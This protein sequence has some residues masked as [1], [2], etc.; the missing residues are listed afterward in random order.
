MT[1]SEFAWE[2]RRH[3]FK[4]SYPRALAPWP[5]ALPAD[6]PAAERERLQARVAELERGAQYGWGQTVDFGPFRKEGFL[7]V[8]YLEIAGLYDAWGWWPRDLTGLKVADVGCFTG[9]HSLLMAARGAEVLAVDELPGHLAQCRFL[10]ETFGQPRVSTLQSSLYHVHE[11]VAPASLDLILLSGV[12]YHLSDMLVG[13]YLLRG[14]LKPGGTL[15]IETAAVDDRK[16]S[17]ADFGRYVG[18]M[19]W[20]P[21][22][23]CIEDMCRYMGYEGAELRFYKPDRCLVRAR[24]D[25]R[26]TIPFRRGMHWDF[27]A[28]DDERE[29][30]MDR[31]G[32]AG[33]RPRLW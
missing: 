23:L 3:F 13:L 28:L 6:L 1:P 32:L 16:R 25:L 19:W 30:S 11:H 2:I 17:F 33:V 18:G 8:Q 15:L 12:L 9:G 5:L 21:S 31:H 20:K 7:G 10:C 22:A 29:R 14:L 24:R 27:A 26:E 4:G